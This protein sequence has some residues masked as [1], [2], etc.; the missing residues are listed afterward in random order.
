[1]TDQERE[2]L[3]E[4]NLPT[5]NELLQHCSAIGAYCMGAVQSLAIRD[6][7]EAPRV[8]LEAAAG[9]ESIEEAANLYRRSV[10][11]RGKA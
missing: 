10:R 5:V 6:G 8:L 2:E 1:M 11:A 3:F 9:C 4:R 7:I